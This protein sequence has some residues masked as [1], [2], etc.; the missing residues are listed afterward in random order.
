MAA[1]SAQPGHAAVGVR[2]AESLLPHLDL[3]I[4]LLCQRVETRLHLLF[5]RAQR[6]QYRRRDQPLGIGDIPRQ[7]LLLGGGDDPVAA[8]ERPELLWR[9]GQPPPHSDPAWDERRIKRL[10]FLYEL[11]RLGGRKALPVIDQALMLPALD[12]INSFPHISEVLND[13]ASCRVCRFLPPPHLVGVV[14][15]HILGD[16]ADGTLHIP[17]RLI[18]QGDAETLQLCRH[19]LAQHRE[20]LL[21]MARDKD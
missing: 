13:R 4:Q 12:L 17:I 6:V 21:R 15:R 11:C 18:Q 3:H 7:F 16:A 10:I 20:S 8:I 14:A 5:L 1:S 9:E 19:F 2:Q